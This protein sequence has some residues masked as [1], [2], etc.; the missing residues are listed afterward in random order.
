MELPEQL[1]DSP[2]EAIASPSDTITKCFTGTMPQINNVELNPSDLMIVPVKVQQTQSLALLDTGASVSLVRADLASTLQ[3]LVTP[4]ISSVKGLGGKQVQ[5]KG[6][7]VVPLEVHGLRLRDV[8]LLIVPSDMLNHKIVLGTDCLTN[9]HLT[10]DPLHDRISGPLEKGGSW[11]LY[12]H[13]DSCLVV[14]SHIPVYA[15]EGASISDNLPYNIAIETTIPGNVQNCNYCQKCHSREEGKFL[16]D[17]SMGSSSKLSYLIGYAGIC[18]RAL[19]NVLVA[20]I[21][22]N[23]KKEVIAVGDHLGYIDSIVEMSDRSSDNL[24]VNTI[25]ESTEWTRDRIRDEISFCDDIKGDELGQVYEMLDRCSNVMSVGSKDIGFAAVTEH[26][27]ELCDYTP[28]CHKPRQFPEPVAKAIDDECQ[29]LL[30]LDI[31]EHSKSPWNARVVPVFKRDNSLRLCLDYRDLNKVT[32]ADKYP[33]PDLRDC[34]Y[35]LHNKKIFTAIDLTSGFHQVPLEKSS[36]EFTAFSARRGHYQFKRLSFG[37]KNCP[38][39]FQRELQTV[40]QTF[41]DKIIIYIDDILIISESIQEHIDIVE[42]VLQTLNSHGIK[43]HVKKCKFFQTEVEFLG[44]QISQ[45][46]ISKCEKYLDTVRN[47]PQPQTVSE[48]RGFLGTINFQRKFLDRCSEIA[49]PL[50]R[51]TGKDGK[52]KLVW[53]SEMTESF[54]KLKEEMLKEIKLSFPDYSPSANLLELYVDASAYGAGA[55]LSQVQGG[56]RRIILFASMSFSKAQCN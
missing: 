45:N 16:Y 27:I 52:T 43:I 19:Q 8:T 4:T 22:C 9:N 56:E 54:Q 17:G 49:Q 44:H 29:K 5:C 39:A 51:L 11:D 35:S 41:S 46:G 14:Y 20:K 23:G 15:S 21:N 31:I 12:L 53:T 47:F 36:R 38:S 1:I 40:L 55:T 18:D 50:S 24:E 37:L 10:L 26:K 6:V 30:D 7:I 25:A 42:R 32:K 28:I 13:N 33:M 48:L 3:C 2:S 34:I